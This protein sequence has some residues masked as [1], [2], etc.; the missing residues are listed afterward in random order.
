MVG[1]LVA[2]SVAASCTWLE[3]ECGGSEDNHCDGNVQ[4][5]CWTKYSDSHKPGNPYVWEEVPCDAGQVCVTFHDDH[6]DEVMCLHE[7]AALR[8]CDD[9]STDATSAPCPTDRCVLGTR[10]LS[11]PGGYVDWGVP[12]CVRFCWEGSPHYGLTTCSEPHDRAPDVTAVEV[13]DDP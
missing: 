9:P 1:A 13:V 6:G 7:D 10:P 2:A 5:F 12:E 3:D 8:S 4:V 11:D